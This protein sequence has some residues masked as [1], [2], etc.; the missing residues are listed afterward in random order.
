MKNIK[1]LIILFNISLLFYSCSSF[2]EAGKVL[3]NEK[4]LGNDEFLIKKK[5]PL[6]A[7]PD[8]DKLPVPTP[9]VE[10]RDQ[11]EFEKMLGNQEKSSVSKN[12]K[13]ST[14]E[15]SILNQIK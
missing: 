7:P 6:S 12:T 13:A 5:D 14:S 9:Q 1:I 3:R 4:I 8:F 2:S 11:N 10:K 15:K